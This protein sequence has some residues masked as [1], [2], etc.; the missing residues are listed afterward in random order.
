MH[1]NAGQWDERINYKVEL[2]T[3]EM[4]IEDDGFT[5]YF[6]NF[7][8]VRGHS[9]GEGETHKA[10][11]EEE[12]KAHV[13]KSKFVGSN[14]GGIKSEDH[15]STFYRNYILGNDQT[16]W[17]SGLFGIAQLEMSEMY[18]GV[19][20]HL[21]GRDAQLKYSFVVKPGIDPDVIQIAY[22]GHNGIYLDQEGNLHISSIFGEIVESK[23]VAWTEGEMGK[24]SVPVE[25]VI[26]GNTVHFNFPSSYAKD[27][28]LIID[29]FLTFSTF[30]GSTADNWGF[31]AAPDVNTNL[32]G[33]GVVFGLGYPITSGVFDP[34]FNGGTIDLAITKFNT[35][36][37]GLLYSTYIGGSGSETPNS[38]VAS[39]SGE[40]YIFGI[41]SSINFPMAGS[42]FDN[43]YN[44]G[45]SI[46][47]NLTNNLGF[48]GGSDLYVARL[49]A[50]GSTLVAS[51]YVGGSGNDGL[52]TSNLKF[53]YGDQFRGEIILDDAGMVYVASMTESS[54]FPTMMGSQGALSGT[55]DAVL[56]KMP[57]TLNSMIWSTY[58]GGSGNETGNAV[59]VASNGTVY[60]AGGT[61][62]GNLPITNGFDLSFGGVT[63]GYLARFNGTTGAQMSGTHIGTNEYDQAYFVQLDLDD[64]VYV[65]G[66]TQANLGITAGLYGNANS[67]QFVHKYNPTLSTQEWKTMLGAGTGNVEI[68]PTAFLVSDCY[69]I[70]V[71]GWGGVL[72]ANP[73]V[74]QAV[75]STT[76]GFPVTFDAFQ[77]TTNGSNFW[78]AVLSENA[79]T[80]KY[81]TY[82]GGQTS[83]YNH[84]DGG[85]SRFDKG[86]RIYHAVCGACG[87]NAT[88]FTTTPG[89]WS[90]TNQ[91]SNCNMAA[92]KF[93]LNVI[94]AA[95]SDPNPSVCIPNPVVF[96]NN[97]LN[98]NYY[99]WDF[100]DGNTS[101]ATDP[102]HYYSSPGIYYGYLVALDT[103]GCYD[104]DTAEFIVN[105]GEFTGGA[106]QPTTSICPGESYQLE[107]FGGTF[108]AWS[109]A[110]FLDDSTSAT[111]VATV[112]QTTDF[113]VIVSDSCGTD[114]LFVT[115][116]VYLGNTTISNDTSVC[117][118]N[119][120]DL[121]A[122]G[123]VSYEWNPATGLDDAFS[124]NP[125]ATPLVTTLYTV[126]ITTSN[127]CEIIDSV[128]VAVYFD[129][130]QPQMPDS[131]TLCLG[132]S[133]NIS[134]SGADEYYWSPN[135]AISSLTGSVVIVNPDSDMYYFC[136]FSN[137]CGIDRDSVFISV[138]T[139]DISAFN[140]T[141]V[142]PGEPVNLWA[143]GGATYWWYPSATL[144][145]NQASSVVAT[146]FETT[147]YY[148]DGTD[149]N[150]CLG[151][152]SV[153]VD[154]FPNPGVQAVSDVYAF[155]GDNIQLGA[156]TLTPGPLVWYPAEFLTCVS[157]SNPIANPN[158]N[159]TYYVSYTDVNGCKA[160]DTVNIFYDPILYVPNTFTPGQG[161]VNPFF[162][163]E[164]GNIK[165][166]EMLIFNR[167]GELICTL[168]S[169]DEHWDGTYEGN[170]CQDGTYVWKIRITDFN[171][172]EQYY[173]GH[174][175]LLRE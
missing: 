170:N 14:W 54:N 103:N 90:P 112:D 167:W 32:F 45:P 23:P 6:H 145:S 40:L 1:P 94:E 105:V 92:F 10:H 70:Y 20:V 136:D 137:A 154:V 33:G 53:N 134:V 89:V 102:T 156:T 38:I 65:L 115:L 158:Q 146:P 100:G 28:V 149:A 164:G 114:T 121:Y 144:N 15:Y 76:N 122:T 83:S 175:N 133:I 135:T 119:S 171:D 35:T 84:V 148:V 50:N 123:G 107:A 57:A 150:G 97:S 21:S 91:S 25:F 37:T 172:S 174:V 116:P 75:N 78:I 26:K 49:S 110:Q 59:A 99:F 71:S 141:I 143:T 12:L 87:G 22:D 44:G 73:N 82:M 159:Y 140:D 64:H 95:V 80:L 74:S 155:Y 18:P 11:N 106:I 31:T 30:S 63:D 52:N 60:M 109:P 48:T 120:V 17:K 153:F 36:G 151:T 165:T 42:P 67:G 47:N 132:N 8:S 86:G 29:P 9:H 55:Q 68:S 117:I 51:T 27:Q 160:S 19:D 147:E 69:D 111:P 81:A 113:M 46:A 79:A 4:L 104:A 128:M 101:T 61:T 96:I 3:G 166:F 85:T 173:V 24:R 5:Y 118:G 77:A 13:I 161:Q 163:A 142:C 41:T 16:K 139:A 124:P 131:L 58:F 93:E 130:P 168:E 88:G 2:Q 157:C 34:T 98:G 7:N 126:L 138:L 39:P 66:Q 56:F 72:N 43:S 125:T 169:I 108:Y 129:P 162:K 152:D 62:S 127:G